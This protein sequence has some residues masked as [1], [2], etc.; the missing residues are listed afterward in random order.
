MDR[1]KNRDSTKAAN[2][3][4]ASRPWS[5]PC[6]RYSNPKAPSKSKAESFTDPWLG[7][8]PELHQR[9]KSHGE[10]PLSNS[11]LTPITQIHRTL[12]QTKRSPESLFFSKNF[13]GIVATHFN[14]A[15]ND[16]LESNSPYVEP[17][18]MRFVVCLRFITTRS[19]KPCCR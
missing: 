11:L 16:I 5:A 19:A 7:V 8:I 18:A 13:T 1:H 2:V 9:C 14:Y 12:R 3:W 15:S 10:S 6:D 17:S 4:S